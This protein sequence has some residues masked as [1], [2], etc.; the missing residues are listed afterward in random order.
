MQGRFARRVQV[1]V[2]AGQ[3]RVHVHRAHLDVRRVVQH[4]VLGRIVPD[5]G[6]L[7]LDHSVEDAA[8]GDLREHELEPEIEVGE[9]LGGDDVPADRHV[10]IGR[11]RAHDER[12]VDHG[13]AGVGEGLAVVT[14]PAGGRLAVEEKAPAGLALRVREGVGRHL[15][16]VHL[17]RGRRGLGGLGA[18]EGGPRHERAQKPRAEP[19]PSR[20]AH[21]TSLMVSGS[22]RTMRSSK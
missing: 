6:A 1:V 13:P 15:R 5:C 22:Q 11:G 4:L 10:R 18:G 9:G 20:G 17:R 16:R 12:A 7:L 19:E 8:V 21:Q 2:V 3:V 14:A